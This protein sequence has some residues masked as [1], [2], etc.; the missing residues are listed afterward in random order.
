MFWTLIY[1][2]TL[3]NS[4]WYI[5]VTQCEQMLELLPEQDAI[6]LAPATSTI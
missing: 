5:Q 1:N 4:I 2:I 3:V 6:N